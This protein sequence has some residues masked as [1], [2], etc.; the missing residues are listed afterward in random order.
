MAKQ[1]EDPR[2]LRRRAREARACAEAERNHEIK[3]KL[4]GIAK[5]YEAIADLAQERVLHAR[6][7][8][9]VVPGRRLKD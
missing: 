1:I 5:N 7:Q 9:E 6:A 3:R 8:R 4:R 2:Y